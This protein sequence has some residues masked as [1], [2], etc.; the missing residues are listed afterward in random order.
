[1]YFS[2]ISDLDTIFTITDFKKKFI[3]DRILE[4]ILM[5]AFR[6]LNI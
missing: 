6:I 5:G 1:M 4:T 3:C 2:F